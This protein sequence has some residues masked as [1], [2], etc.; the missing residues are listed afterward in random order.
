M[1]FLQPPSEASRFLLSPWQRLMSNSHVPVLNCIPT[2]LQK[3]C[4]F[5]YETNNKRTYIRRRISVQ[6]NSSD[7]T[8]LRREIRL[9]INSLN[10][11]TLPLN[12]PV[13][14]TIKLDETSF[15]LYG[16]SEVFITKCMAKGSA[17]I[18]GQLPNSHVYT[19]VYINY[20]ADVFWLT[21]ISFLRHIYSKANLTYMTIFCLFSF[22]GVK[23]DHYWRL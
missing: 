19:A 23:H 2:R 14:T 9:D 13:W 21:F 6:S 17:I 5:N 16:L 11:S 4:R 18:C 1:E 7:W 8:R 15:T 20:E 10:V 12:H 22:Y 3:K